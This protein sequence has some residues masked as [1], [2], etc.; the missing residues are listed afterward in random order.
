MRDGAE[1]NEERGSSHTDS[2]RGLAERSILL[3]F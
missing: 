3:P 2:K 1:L